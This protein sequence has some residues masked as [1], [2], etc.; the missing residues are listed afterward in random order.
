M[1][2]GNRIIVRK[3]FIRIIR[4]IILISCLILCMLFCRLRP[5]FLIEL[6]KLMLFLFPPLLGCQLLFQHLLVTKHLKFLS[7]TFSFCLTLLMKHLQFLSFVCSFCLTL[8]MK[9]F[10]S[11]VFSFLIS[12]DWKLL[13]MSI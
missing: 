4:M 5:I 6:I 13:L 1:N 8:T 10:Y 2:R 3:L 12:Q 11:L 7:L 9:H